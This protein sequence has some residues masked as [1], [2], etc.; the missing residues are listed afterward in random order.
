MSKLTQTFPT[1]PNTTYHRP[2]LP[3]DAL[4]EAVSLVANWEQPEPEHC[5]FEFEFIIRAHSY[6]LDAAIKAE[7]GTALRYGSEFKP[8][9]ILSLLLQNHPLWDSIS[10]SLSNGI[11][12]PLDRITCHARRRSIQQAID[13]GNH[14]SARDQPDKLMDL[15]T[16]GVHSGFSLPLPTRAVFKIPDVALASVGI[17]NQLTINDGGE[18]TTKDRLTHDQTFEF[19]TE[20]SLNNRVRMDIVNPVVFGWCLSRILHYIVDLRRRHPSTKIF[21]AK[22]DW[23]RAFRRGHLSAPDAAASS[24]LETPET[25]LLSL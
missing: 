5:N 14:K 17:S 24:C 15:L 3:A 16:S 21:L 10:S 19:G 18:V 25:F 20:K 4:R 13:R 1:P 11:Q 22:T 12:Y 8:P 7:G 6:D 23:N 9:S 2:R